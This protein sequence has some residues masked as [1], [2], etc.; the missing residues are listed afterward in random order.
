MSIR[1][2]ILYVAVALALIMIILSIYVNTA[3]A[4]PPAVT[5]DDTSVQYV[6]KYENGRVCLY[7]GKRIVE[8][9]TEINYM[10]LPYE[11]RKNL[12]DGIVTET[13]EE[14]LQLVEDFDG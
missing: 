3:H 13:Q 10:G 5:Q 14:A 4:N 8:T 6:L 1:K 2:I 12:L 11:D 7:E 9:F